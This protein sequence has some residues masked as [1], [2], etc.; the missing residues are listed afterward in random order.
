MT[1]AA[2][3]DRYFVRRTGSSGVYPM[4]LPPPTEASEHVRPAVAPIAVRSSAASLDLS[5]ILEAHRFLT[6]LKKEE[7]IGEDVLV[8]SVQVLF[9]I[10]F[11]IPQLRMPRIGAGPDGMVGFTWQNQKRHVSIE[12]FSD[13]RVEFF[14]EDLESGEL[15]EEEWSL[16]SQ[17]SPE[18][19]RMLREAL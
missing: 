19:L 14:S 3:D 7:L 8:R 11:E 12:V 16:T 9:S 4:P 1:A 2:L 10:F 13:G 18:A 5:L 15:S 6:F 17:P